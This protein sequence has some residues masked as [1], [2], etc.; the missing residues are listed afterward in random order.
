MSKLM[1]S[2][3]VSGFLIPLLV[4]ALCL[5]GKWWHTN[6]NNTDLLFLLSPLSFITSLFTGS[7]G[8]FD[9]EVGYYHKSL[10]IAIDKSCAGF[11]FL[12]IAFG[13]ICS[14]LYRVK[15]GVWKN[16]TGILS[17]LF[18]AYGITLAANC[19]RILISVKSLHF[20]DILP[21]LASNWFHEATGSFIFISVLIGM[22][23]I[24]HR[25]QTQNSYA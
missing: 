4:I 3:S 10:S 5:A 8:F 12:I 23:L 20:S 17:A 21:W 25:Q 9:P 15:K 22:C 14:M 2:K 6:S 19:S 18:I 24:I 7:T 1:N 13:S 16:L 11:N